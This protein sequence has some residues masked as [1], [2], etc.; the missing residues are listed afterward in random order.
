VNDAPSF[1][2]GANQTVNEDIGVQSVSNW[3]T[4]ISPGPPDEPTQTVAL[5]VT[6]DNT[7]LFS[8]QPAVSLTGALTYTPAANANGST[9]VSVSLKDNGGTANGGQDTSAVQ[10]FTI[11]VTAV[12]DAP[13]NTVP[14]SQVI[15]AAHTLTLSSANGNGISVADLDAGSNAI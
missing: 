14:G 5:T 10:T 1:T 9:I 11:N 6:N 2:K 13:V 15:A 7:S 12:N 3:A 8:A 4:S